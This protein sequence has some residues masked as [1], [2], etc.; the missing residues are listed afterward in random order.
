MSAFPFVPWILP[1]ADNEGE[2]LV[3]RTRVCSQA[4]P[5]KTRRNVPLC[6]L[7]KGW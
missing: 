5:G 6:K 7:K 1:E 3:V 2:S 4:L